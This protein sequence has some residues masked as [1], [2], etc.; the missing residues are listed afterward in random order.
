[1]YLGFDV[2]RSSFFSVMVNVTVVWMTCFDEID[3]DV[4]CDE[5]RL[6]VCPI[7]WMVNEACENESGV[8]LM[9]MAQVEEAG[10]SVMTDVEVVHQGGQEVEMRLQLEAFLGAPSWSLPSLL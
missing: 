3:V 1:M 8:W 9:M 6:D 10:D 4:G 2:V 5:L 7:F